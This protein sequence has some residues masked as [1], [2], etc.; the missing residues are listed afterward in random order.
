MN[1]NRAF[2]VEYRVR[3]GIIEIS[4]FQRTKRYVAKAI[5][6]ASI[7][8]LE[9]CLSPVDYEANGFIYRWLYPPFEVVSKEI[10]LPMLIGLWKWYGARTKP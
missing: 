2:R 6:A 10:D 3:D 8:R 7:K 4:R 5:T 1:F 9:I